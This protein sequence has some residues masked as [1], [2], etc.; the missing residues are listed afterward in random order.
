[1]T[2]LASKRRWMARVLRKLRQAF[3]SMK[4]RLEDPFELLV[5]TILSQHTS[6]INSE[7]AFQRLKEALGTITPSLLAQTPEK[8]ITRHIRCA[9][10][11]KVKA[12]R[13]KEVS[14]LIME[15][16]GGD[17]S[18]V[19]GNPQE[20]RR[21]LMSL[22]GV[23]FKT[24]DVVLAFSARLPVIPIDTH[25]FTLARRLQISSSSNYEEVKEAY[26]RLI[27]EAD[28]AEAHL[29]L[30]NL[31]KKY[32]LARNPRCERC[33]IRELCPTSGKPLS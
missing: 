15:R 10:L 13:L 9:G 21:F 5:A 1:M 4:H 3:G 24:A 23:G 16:L 33:P 2:G 20:A 12:R 30:L 14:R 18:K 26:E 28:R 6:D 32:C 31:G 25:L 22:P 8:E 7:R 11:A 27:P 29:L 17:L 19:L